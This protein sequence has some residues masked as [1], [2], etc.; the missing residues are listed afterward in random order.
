MDEGFI[1]RGVCSRKLWWSQLR[2]ASTT[3]HQ[4]MRGAYP[5]SRKYGP[6]GRLGNGLGSK[7]GG[8]CRGERLQQVRRE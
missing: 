7:V 1:F 6:E 2:R 4:E 8:Q 3:W 5:M